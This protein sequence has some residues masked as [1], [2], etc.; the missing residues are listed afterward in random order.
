MP[1]LT[2]TSREVTSVIFAK[3]VDCDDLCVLRCLQ[4][5]IGHTSS[6]RPV[7]HPDTPSS[8]LVSYHKPNRPVKS[9]AISRWI[10]SVLESAGIDTSI[11]K[12]HSMRSAS[13]SK[14]RSRAVLQEEVVKMADWSGTSTF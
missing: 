9:C 1:G 10:K 6:F 7:L 3:Y 5:C 2:K 13:T 4:C 12:G 11:F 14:A 8:L